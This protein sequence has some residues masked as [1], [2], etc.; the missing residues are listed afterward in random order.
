MGGGGIWRNYNERKQQSQ[1]WIEAKPKSKP[2]GGG[3]GILSVIHTTP[4]ARIVHGNIRH[5]W[6]FMKLHALCVT[7]V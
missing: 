2:K 3:E 1:G 7:S 4:P 6:Q 5:M